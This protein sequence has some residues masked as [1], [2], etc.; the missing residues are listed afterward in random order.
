MRLLS[1]A[2]LAC[3]VCLMPALAPQAEGK[4]LPERLAQALKS[5]RVLVVSLPAGKVP[6]TEPAEAK[7]LRELNFVVTVLPEDQVDPDRLNGIDV[8]FLPSQWG[9]TAE[10]LKKFDARTAQYQRFVQRGGGLV[11][12]SP[13]PTHTETCTPQLL[14]Y[15]ITFQNAYDNRDV[16]RVNLDPTHFITA[17]LPSSEMPF[18]FD[19]MITVDHR[20]TLLARQ[21]KT[22]WASLAAC[23]L[24][25]G[26]IVVQTGG[27][28]RGSIIPLG[29]EIVRRMVVWAAGRERAK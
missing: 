21:K 19:P 18:P 13:N 2:A 4:I 29:D 28:A 9:Y 8:I 16:E 10:L 15:P 22:G 20:Y 23:Q 25:D 26:R 27:V 6:G 7:R 5:V 14:P 17:G 12:D 1:V 24:G 3:V 11:I